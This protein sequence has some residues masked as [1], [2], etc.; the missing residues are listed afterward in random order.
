M[1]TYVTFTYASGTPSVG[2][3]WA[4]LLTDEHG[5]PV[6]PEAAHGVEMVGSGPDPLTAAIDLAERL[7]R[8]VTLGE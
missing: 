2:P 7:G 5:H 4:A 1:N 8:V 6:R 3:G